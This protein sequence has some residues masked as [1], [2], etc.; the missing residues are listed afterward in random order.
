MKYL[1]HNFAT[2][3]C[4]S[5]GRKKRMERLARVKVPFPEVERV[6]WNPEKMNPEERAQWDRICAMSDEDK[7]AS[8]GDF[9]YKEILPEADQEEREFVNT[10]LRA[11]EGAQKRKDKKKGSTLTQS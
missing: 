8:I 11:K 9:M 4:L 7:L 1:F 5:M 2:I 3:N 6:E 10:V